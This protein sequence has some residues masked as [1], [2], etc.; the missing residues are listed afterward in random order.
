[1]KHFYRLHDSDPEV[2]R[3]DGAVLI[4][5]HRDAIKWNKR[6]WGIFWA[7]NDFKNGIRRYN[8][9]E[10][11][12]AW[13]TEIDDG[14]K[15]D[16]L[17]RINS[18]LRP[19]CLIETKSGFH[20]YWYCRGSGT[21]LEEYKNIL[22][23]RLRPFYDGDKR[24]CDGCRILRVPNYYHMKDPNNP[25][26]IKCHYENNL[27]YT[28]QQMIETYSEVMPVQK[29]VKKENFKVTGDSFWDKV[30]NIPSVQ[31]LLRLSGH[32]AVNGERFEV[33]ALGSGK[34]IIFVN[35]KST[36]CW[37]DLNG[38]IGSTDSGGPTLGNWLWWY[39]R[40]WGKVAK[41]L[42]EVFPELR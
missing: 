23:F 14:L 32:P 31:G 36:S 42:R 19:S 27:R 11:I 38:M 16:M 29:F 8:K 33:K 20:L 34:K 2:K 22:K 41:V 40:D 26:L 7:V 21:S 1:M 25:F 18:G 4:K 24:A 12:N 35:G 5:N 30:V 3:R 37:I 10:K 17:D 9:I 15:H 39:L 13:F 28:T 6:G